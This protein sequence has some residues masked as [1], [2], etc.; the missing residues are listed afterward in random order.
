MIPP[1]PQGILQYE[2]AVPRYHEVVNF[3]TTESGQTL[4]GL[5]NRISRSYDAPVTDIALN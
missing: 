2:L 5:T 4:T 1:I 3:S